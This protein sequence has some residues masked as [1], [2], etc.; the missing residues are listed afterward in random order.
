M[1]N[2][3]SGPKQHIRRAVVLLEE[4]HMARLEHQAAAEHHSALAKMYAER[5]KRLEREIQ[6]TQMV[7]APPGSLGD[8]VIEQPALY[9]LNGKRAKNTALPN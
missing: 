8:V 5:A 4:A 6:Q 7:A 9:A 1:F 2:L 3:F